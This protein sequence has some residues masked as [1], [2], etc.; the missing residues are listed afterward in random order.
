[1]RMT[2]GRIIG[3][4]IVVLAAGGWGPQ[5][6]TARAD[7][8]SVLAYEV[9]PTSPLTNAQGVVG[10]PARTGPPVSTDFSTS[11]QANFFPL[12]RT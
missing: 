1:M 9:A 8:V 6:E 4:A 7:A 11:R 5:G 2:R 3:A 12:F 10:S